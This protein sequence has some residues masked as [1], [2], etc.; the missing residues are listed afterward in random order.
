MKEDGDPGAL[1]VV[2][3]DAVNGDEVS[4]LAEDLEL[5]SLYTDRRVEEI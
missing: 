1:L 3:G 2:D 4:R 5:M